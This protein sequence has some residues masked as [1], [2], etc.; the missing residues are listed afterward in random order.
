MRKFV[1]SNIDLMVNGTSNHRWVIFRISEIYLNYAEALNESNP[2]HPDILT[3]VNKTRGRSDVKMIPIGDTDQDVL[4]K[5]IRNERR[6]E[7]AF[8]DHRLWDA[9][10]WMI[11]T[12]VLNADL[13]GVE[14][15]KNENETFTYKKI[16][17]EKRVFSPKMYFYPIPG[18][19]I[20]N[21]QVMAAGWPQNPLW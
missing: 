6:I 21:E 5:R 12:D 19:V 2:G 15:R 18:S 10:R 7:L 16:N 20:L 17:V 1:D 4:R 3:Y 11:A 13:T 14:I 9:R 8:E